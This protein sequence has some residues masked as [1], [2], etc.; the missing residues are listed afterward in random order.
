MDRRRFLTTTAALA[1]A[2]TL[3][4]EDRSP[5]DVDWLS[6]VQ[7]LPR[8]PVATAPALRSLLIDDH[9]DPIAT[10]QAWE[11][12]R[13]QLRREWLK[14]LGPLSRGHL[15][16]TR[17][18][19]D[20]AVPKVTIIEEETDAG[21]VR[22]RIRYEV[23]SA[24]P[25]EAYLLRPESLTDPKYRGGGLRSRA[26]VAVFHST[27]P[28]S[29]RQPAGVEGVPEKAFG[30]QLAKRGCV[31]ICPRNYLWPEN[32][33]IDAKG[34]AAKFLQRHPKS[35]GMDRMLLDALIA[36]DL[37]TADPQVDPQRIG[38]IG[39]SLGA[40]EVLY[41]AAFDD[42]VR[43]SV[44]SEGGIGT[45]FSNWHDPWYLGDAIQQP[46]FVREHHELLAMVA[47]RPFLLVGGD[48]ADGDRSW[49]FIEAALPVYGM[50]DEP[51]HL[52]LLN[53]RQGHNVPP[54]VNK[55]MLEWLLTYLA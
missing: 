45:S 39:H 6:D 35:V 38:C 44:S 30:L 11:R 49:P 41:L 31:A 25:V 16:R 1:C 21:V 24:Q 36:V 29:L 46:E 2:S 34:E 40:K 50:Y 23:E 32:H 17:L 13:E 14:F 4:S 52:G 9:G 15:E 33:R 43:A 3:R 7:R 37:L 18:G 47:P 12:R 20:A 48:S 26:G 51:K 42:R 27:V 22:Q 55:R 54:E 10:Q 8:Q 28:H 53:H 5:N 19:A